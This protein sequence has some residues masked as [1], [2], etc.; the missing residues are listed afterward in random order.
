M[1]TGSEV[2][3]YDLETRTLEWTYA[4]PNATAVSIAAESGYLYVGT[5]DGQLWRIDMDSLDEVRLGTATT[6]AEP[7]KL[8]A[9]TGIQIETVY[10]GSPPPILAVAASGDIVSV[11]GEGKIVGRGNIPGAADFVRLGNSPPT[12]AMIPDEITDPAAEASVL[13]GAVS[14]D[15]SAV[16]AMLSSPR[17]GQTPVPLQL[18]TL[19]EAM[20]ASI[21]ARIEE[22]LLPGIRSPPIRR[23]C[24]S[25]TRAA[26]ASWTPGASPSPR[27][28]TRPGRRLRSR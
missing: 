6:P 3:V 1:A 8:A 14:M 27:T 20:V 19:D 18:V 7:V 5:S 4:I 21:Q 26:S 9:E 28:S 10:A 24:W 23:S 15:E 22:G 25:P 16:E 13:A 12:V 2:R 17:T 11:D